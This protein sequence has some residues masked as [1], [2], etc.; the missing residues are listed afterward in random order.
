MTNNHIGKTFYVAQ[1]LPATN[2][3]AGFAALTWVQVKGVQTLPQLGVSH[4]TIDI[5]DLATGFTT[6]AKGAAAG[7]STT[8]TFRTVAS[9][10]GQA[11]VL[12]QCLDEAGPISVKIGVGS[13]TDSGD[14]PALQTG[15]VVEYA[16]GIAHSYQ[17]NQGDNSS[18]EGFQFTFE[19]NNFTVTA[20]EPS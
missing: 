15:D 17:P 19:Q 7:V 20:T 13:G 9:D 5:P 12:E 2:D 8:A 1:A 14:G 6:K 16:Q 10:P 4:S 18:H 3:A 11:D